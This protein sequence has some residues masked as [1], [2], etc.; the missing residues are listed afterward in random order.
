MRLL[1]TGLNHRNAP[2]ELREKV[3][4]SPDELP[5]ALAA[6]HAHPHVQEAVILSTCNRVELFVTYSEQVPDLMQFLA[7]R[8]PV[9]EG[10]LRAHLYQHRD[11][12]AVRHLFRVASS[13]DSMVVGEPQ[14]LG[15]VKEAFAAARAAGVVG[16]NLQTLLQSAFSVAKRVRTETAIGSSSVSI[17]SVAVDLALKIFSSL[18][19]KR[20]LL[21]GA[22][23][24]GELA[25]KHLL[26]KGAGSMLVSNRTMARAERLAQTF[27]GKVLP[28]G[29]LQTQADQADIVITSTGSH[30]YVFRREDGQRFLSKR[31]GRPMFFIDISVPRN[32]DPEIKRVEGVFLYDIDDLQSFAVDNLADRSREGAKAERLIDGEVAAFT[33]RSHV[34]DAVPTLVAL[35]GSVEAM[36]LA[37]LRRFAGQLEGITPAHREAVEALSRGLANKFL[38]API[39]ALRAAAQ[40]GDEE[41]LALLRSTFRLP[42]LVEPDASPVRH[43]EPKHALEAAPIDV[44]SDVTSIDGHKH[45]V[46]IAGRR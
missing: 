25:A 16:R 33:Q 31:R 43:I 8:F 14:I 4:I 11:T 3:A 29:E 35:Q 5:A 27:G 26:S 1:V 17:A 19:G 40:D 10:E 37:E 7:T 36:R 45:A 30:E 42:E 32:I 12:E 44:T 24:M 28:Y 6:L 18:A 9:S 23:K 20:V 41:R 34:V 15:Q 13:L 2:V 38:H 39:Q 46:P 21:V 22:G